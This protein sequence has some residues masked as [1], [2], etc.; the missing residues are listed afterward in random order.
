MFKN[1]NFL[2]NYTKNLSFRKM[3][4]TFS[5]PVCVFLFAVTTQITGCGA[6]S[7]YSHYGSGGGGGG[8]DKT[9]DKCGTDKSTLIVR[10]FENWCSISINGAAPSTEAVISKCVPNG[11]VKLK[12]TALD[13]FILGDWHHTA[14]DEGHGDPGKISG[15]TSSTTIEVTKKS[16]V[17]IC[18]PFTDGSGCPTSDQCAS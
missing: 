7:S 12:A 9:P 18:C 10:N 2:K 1:K 11:N 4:V 5:V 16:C 8:D 3:N 13:G 17:W 6:A 15:G 14:N